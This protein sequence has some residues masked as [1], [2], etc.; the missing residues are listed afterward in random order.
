MKI[1]TIYDGTIQSKA[2]LRYGLR[3]AKEQG[4]ELTVLQVFQS[5]LFMDYDASPKAEE[6]ARIEAARHLHDAEVIIRD[7]DTTGMRVRIVSLDGDTLEE[8][9][10]YAKTWRADL[11]LSAPRYKA[12]AGR[13]SCPVFILP[14]VILVPVDNSKSLLAETQNIIAE[15]KASGSTV[16]LLGIIPVHLY[17]T[18]EKKQLKQ[19]HAAT[20]AMTKNMKKVLVE[21][22][23]AVS[24]EMRYGY[25]D[26]EILKAAEE[27]SVSLIML[28]AGG[29]TPSELTKAAAILLDEPERAHM[30]IQVIQGAGA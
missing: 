5:S 17:S 18:E 10:Q 9:L 12:I 22:G 8:A 2:A 13:A 26:E 11:I 16:L 29:K 7:A 1:L 28:P 6:I 27:F 24:E 19:L 30:P 23:I 14:G 20:S 15:A 25:P 21:Q 3:K 4:G